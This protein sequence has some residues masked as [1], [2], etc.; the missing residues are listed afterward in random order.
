MNIL[1]LNS[2]YYNELCTVHSNSLE[3]I[4]KR[5][6]M[7]DIKDNLAHSLSSVPFLRTITPS[8]HVIVNVLSRYILQRRD[9]FT[10]ND[11]RSLPLE[12][13]GFI[14]KYNVLPFN[15]GPGINKDESRFS[16]AV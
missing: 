11:F 4:V 12:C 7:A 9:K 3:S 15:F 14:T 1:I 8:A 6:S 16:L 10:G 13:N 5:A 2:T